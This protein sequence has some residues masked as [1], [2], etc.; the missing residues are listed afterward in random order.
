MSKGAEALAGAALIAMAQAGVMALG[1]KA[2]AGMLPNAVALA[3]VLLR[4]MASA[5][6]GR[7][8]RW[9]LPKQRLL[10]YHWSSTTK[11]ESK[12]LVNRAL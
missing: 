8:L 7:A 1:A 12:S 2:Q 9:R 10:R 11:S 6:A 3:D 5:P 4:K